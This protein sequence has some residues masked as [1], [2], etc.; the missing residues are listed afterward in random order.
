MEKR[1]NFTISKSEEMASMFLRTCRKRNPGRQ[2]AIVLFVFFLVANWGLGYCQKELNLSGVWK[3]YLD[4]AGRYTI[5]DEGRIFYADSI[6]L[7]G[8]LDEAGK[9]RVVPKS[10]KTSSLSRRYEFSGKAW[11]RRE[12]NIP[13][14]WRGKRIFL[15]MERTRVTHVFV[16][17]KYVDS[18]MLVC[19]PQRYEL[20]D[21]LT[22]GKHILT[23]CVDNG[24]AC[25]LPEEVFGSHMFTDNTQ[26]N[27]NGILG[28]IT[29]EM[30]PQLSIRK[31]KV[32]PNAE[33]RSGGVNVELDNGGRAVSGVMKV[34][35]GGV[36]L[37]QKV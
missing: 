16:D 12:V 4:T 7:P 25:G 27:W 34:E 9:G 36:S 2:K 19:S 28:K 33:R 37:N 14:K 22:T 35:G 3:L 11:Y 6:R 24:R 10:D 5:A 23:V 18:C 32:T 26:T 1:S 17:G 31:V 8:S 20:T 15:N 30:R 13:E 29:L 21:H